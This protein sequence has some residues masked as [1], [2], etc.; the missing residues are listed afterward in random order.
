M[1]FRLIS[2]MHYTVVA[3]KNPRKKQQSLSIQM[4]ALDDST[5]L[6]DYGLFPLAHPWKIVGV[7]CFCEE[8]FTLSDD[9]YLPVQSPFVSPPFAKLLLFQFVLEGRDDTNRVKLYMVVPTDYLYPKPNQRS[10]EVIPWSSWG[11]HNTR[12]FLG[13]IFSESV[14][15]FRVCTSTSILDFNQHDIA[16]DLSNG[17]VQGICTEPTVYPKVKG[18]FRSN[19]MFKE[20]L[21]TS[22]PY[23]I[24]EHRIK[25]GHYC[26]PEYHLDDC[27][28]VT[29]RVRTAHTFI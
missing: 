23:R 4:C 8:V 25:W 12:C 14:H 3:C 18:F 21:V 1:A 2:N 20:D 29:D 26:D 28:V 9:T 22:L 10:N 5:V 27:I 13:E 6:A 24:V 15:M 16:R 19:G 7:A 11:P 17:T